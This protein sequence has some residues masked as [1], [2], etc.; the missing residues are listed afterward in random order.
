[1]KLSEAGSGKCH[2]LGATVIPG[3]V[4]FAI[5]SRSASALELLFFADAD[6]PDP[7]RV[8]RLDARINRTCDYWHVFVSGIRSG[9]IYAWRAFGP[10]APDQGHR[11]DPAKIL[12]DPYSRGVAVPRLYNREAA[13]LPGDN[14]PFA[15]RSVVA[16]R[17]D[18]DWEGDAPLRRP[19][20]QTVIYEMHLAGFTRHPNSGIAPEKRGTYAGM[21]EKI[22]YLVDLGITAVELLPVFAFDPEDAPLGRLNYW[23][24]CPV[25]FFAPHV[26]YSSRKDPLGPL[27][28]FREMVKAFH[29]AGIEVILDVVFNHTAEGNH[30]GPTHC[31][32]GLE[33]SVYYIPEND[34]SRYA[35]YTGTGN[36]LNANHPTVRRMIVDSLRYWVEEMHV[37]GFRFDLASILSRDENGYPMRNPPVLWDIDTDPVLAGTKLIAEAW[38]AGGLY[39]VGSFI[40]NTWKE[41]NGKFRD[42]VRRFLKGDDSTVRSLAARLLGS[43]DLYG[44]EEREPEQS[45]NFVTCHDGFTLNDLVTYNAKHN[46][47]NGE[48]NRDGSDDNLSWNCGAE[49]P[50]DHPEADALRERQI[51]NFLTI[52]LL[53]LGAPMVLMGDECRRTQGGNNNAYCQDNE[54]S[55][56]DWELAEQHQG[57]RRFVRELVRRRLERDTP[58]GLS[59]NALLHRSR[60]D[61]HGIRLHRPDWADHSHSIA[62]TVR[63]RFAVHLMINAWWKELLFEIPKRSGERVWRRWIDTSRPSPDDICD[64]LEGPPVT[65]ATCRVEPRSIVA[66][67]SFNPTASE[68]KNGA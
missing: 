12:L 57:L 5:F 8:I 30:E 40:G 47:A 64:W 24:Y 58:E 65:G 22:P 25:S 66:L 36:T 52:N 4:N 10:F 33:N 23:G 67:V 37:D 13:S 53:A 68:K 34:R 32:R 38:D 15:L 19:I 3:G 51:R 59:L 2:P 54:L 39:Q 17:R 31:F 60:I 63:G 11:F 6:A 18:F 27:M 16:D 48:E 61:W 28:E 7:E 44:H 41:W 50:V 9:Q 56:F 35:N 14:T 1:M 62:V 21:I 43:P 55:W 45:I 20:S 46:E 29:R 26:A 49:G 42:D